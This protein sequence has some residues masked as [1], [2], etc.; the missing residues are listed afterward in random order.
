MNRTGL[1]IALVV[2]AVSGL[3]FG[4][5][6]QLEL[7]I[8]QHFHA[9]VDENRN[10]FAW[11]VSPPLMLARDIGIWVITL[12]VAPAVGAA[13]IKIVLPHSKML[14]A[15]RSIVFLIATLALGPGLLVNVVLKD[16]WGRPRPIDVT[17]FGGA[18]HYV[19]W[20]D[21]RGDC[22]GNCSFV[23]GD[24]AGAIWTMAPA[25]LTPPPWRALAYGAALVFTAGMA[26]IRVMAGGHFVSDVIF[27]GVFTFLIVWVM[28]A[29]IYRWKRT[30][31]TGFT[32]GEIEGALERFG[33][34]CRDGL[35]WL[36]YR[37]ANEIAGPQAGD[38]G[39]EKLERRRGWW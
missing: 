11:R 16:H 2:A 10:A 12:L 36:G 22:P 24:V 1:I 28:Y 23:S 25:A 35:A 27:A 8:A 14:I 5:Y 34:K 15:G 3:L 21:P 38:D 7:G 33:L 17:Q 18:Q 30:A 29:L 6:P 32:D 26:T 4:L 31:L 37:T 9:Y 20:W 13:V 39:D 19:T